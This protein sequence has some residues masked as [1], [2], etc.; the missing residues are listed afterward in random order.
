M[1]NETSVNAMETPGPE[2]QKGLGFFEKYLSLWVIL[3]ILAGIVLGKIA[4]GV[5]RY[6]DGLAIYV[7]DA[8]VVSIPIAVCLFF[9]M[10]P[11]MV[12]I[13][14]CSRLERM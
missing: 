12:K 2:E 8:P 6:L 11:I 5:A 7:G 1:A 10:Y 4:P 14:R 13:E 3:C 9:M